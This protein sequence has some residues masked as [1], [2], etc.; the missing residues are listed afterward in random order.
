[1]TRLVLGGYGSAI[2]LVELGP[3]GFGHPVEVAEAE[4]PSFVI[5]SPDRRF[6]YACLEPVGRVGAWVVTDDD[7][8]AT[9]GEQPTGGEAPCHLALSPDGRWLGT[10]N[11]A[12]GSVSIH[13]VA[14]D[15]SLGAR[16][17]LVQHRGTA[18]PQADRQDRPHAH[19]VVFTT[20]GL[21]VCDLGL[22]A[23]I[24]YRL[25]DGRLTEESRSAMPPGS[26]PRHLVLDDGIA[27]VV[28]ELGS[29]VTV[30]DVAG[31][32]L[33]ARQTL[34][35]RS[36]NATGENT[37]AEVVVTGDQVLASN[38]G[39]DTVAVLDKVG[40]S[41]RLGDIVACGGSG[42]RWIGLVDGSL[43]VA[44]ERSHAIA[45]LLPA[46]GTWSVVDVLDWP[47]P[48]GCAVLP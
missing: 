26:G 37:A 40:T 20:D 34:S 8:W 21:L 13:P 45:R 32:E 27:Y 33:T 41:L 25:D 30:C 23:V 5:V 19:Q 16:T 14:A 39:D 35:L 44:N 31:L 11:Y 7:A 6:A 10:A 48:T 18:G 2:G 3:E 15:G 9:L 47:S 36:Q 38:R 22:D 4:G 1:V 43:V 24:G 12:S 29:T 42:P 17:D 46:E 28:A